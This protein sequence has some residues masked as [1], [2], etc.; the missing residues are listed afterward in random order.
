MDFGHCPSPRWLKNN[1]LDD[2]AH[3]SGC[4]DLQGSQGLQLGHDLARW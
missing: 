1:H 3:A 2:E 4:S